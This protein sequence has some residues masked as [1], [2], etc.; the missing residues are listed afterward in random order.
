M[1]QSSLIHKSGVLR[2]EQDGGAS[3][4]AKGLRSR[5]DDLYLNIDPGNSMCY[6]IHIFYEYILTYE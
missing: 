6:I 5:L 2:L 1:G 4:E 3:I